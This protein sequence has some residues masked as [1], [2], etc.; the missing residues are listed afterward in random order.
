[1]NRTRNQPQL[2][3]PQVVP[4]SAAELEDVK[5]IE[6]PDG[7]W[8]LPAA[9]NREM[10]PYATLVEAIEES[11]AIDGNEIEPG[12]TLAEAEAQLGVSDWIDP[13]TSAPAE[14]SVPHLEDH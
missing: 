6:R 1:V 11:R 12:D 13:D 9:G 14:D 8:V 10:G 3:R 2:H 5:I 7:F 4:G